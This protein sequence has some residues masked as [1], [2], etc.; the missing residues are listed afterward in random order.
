MLNLGGGYSSAEVGVV[1]SVLYSIICSLFTEK[2]I[3]LL[4]L[5]GV[6]HPRIKGP[7]SILTPMEKVIRLRDIFI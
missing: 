3:L 4:F 2:R 6:E 7:V 5:K 1:V